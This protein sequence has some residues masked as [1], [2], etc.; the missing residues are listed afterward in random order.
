MPVMDFLA[1]MLGFFLFIAWF[2]VLIMVLSDI[3]RS[4]QVAGGTRALW[5]LF[6]IL[7]PWLGVLVYIIVHGRGISDRK[8]HA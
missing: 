1:S 6:V 8:L 5:T 7:I 4:R 2:W 3:F